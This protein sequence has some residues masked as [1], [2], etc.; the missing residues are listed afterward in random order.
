MRFICSMKTLKSETIIAMINADSEDKA[1]EIWYQHY[2]DD[3][4]REGCQL[5]IQPFKDTEFYEIYYG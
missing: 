3:W 5:N 4:G 2:S 1:K